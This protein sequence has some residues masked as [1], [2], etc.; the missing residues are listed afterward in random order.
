MEYDGAH[1]HGSQLQANLPT[2]QGEAEKAL[3]KL[4]EESSRVM[5]ASR[6]D[7]G[8]HAREQVVSFRTKSS[9][10]TQTFVK[11]MNYYLPKDIAVKAAFR[12]SDT[13]N[14]RRNA[15]SREYNYCI[16]DSPTPSPIRRGFT[17]H[18]N[19][20][21]DIEAMNEAC[22]HLVGLH[23]LASFATSIESEVK[24]TVRRIY[25]VKVER[26]GDMVVLNIVAS[27]FLPH[28]VRNTAGALIKVGLGQM[29]SNE[30]R[31][32]LE[33]RTPGKAGPTAPAH[34]LC[35]MRVNYPHSW[36]EI[37]N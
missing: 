32:I 26:D 28:Q 15:T 7:S 3:E 18:I 1:Y 8:V 12:V 31:S 19:G 30:F 20:R 21:L 13:F 29:T 37:C 4:T 34:G 9:L 16:V 5:T 17:Y 23:D 22:Q 33:A 24:S 14:V 2:I 35:L 10:P 11:G 25:R 6:T 27:S 36:E